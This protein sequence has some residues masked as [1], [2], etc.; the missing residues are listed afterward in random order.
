MNKN[1]LNILKKIIILGSGLVFIFALTFYK[2]DQLKKLLQL[3]KPDHISVLYLRLLLNITPDNDDLR[4]ELANQYINLGQYDNA[5]IELKSLLAKDGRHKAKALDARLLMLE[6]DLNDY[7]LITSDAARRET[8][9]TKLQTSIIKISKNPIPV[10]LFPKVI[11]LSLG[12]D[13]PAIAANLYYQ[14]STFSLDLDSRF[15]KLKESAQWYIASGLPYKATEIY[16]ECY[17]L[18]EN[19]TLARQYALLAL[20]TLQSAG[21]N[22]LALEYFRNYQQRFPEDPELLDEAINISLR[23]NNPEQAYELGSLRLALDPDNPEQ[24]KKQFDRA[25]AIGK[26]Q[27]ALTLTQ[28]LIEIVPDDDNIHERLAQIAEWSEKPKLAIKEWLWLA[29]N[30]KDIPAILN[31]VRLS[32]QLNLFSITIEMLEQLSNMRELS[33]EEMSSLLYAYDNLSNS[34]VSK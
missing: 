31:A 20:Q 12:L 34:S 10:S 32:T 17:E 27:S 3:T 25:L 16:N 2:E 1:L 28:R 6:I 29:R 24:I 22:K 23:S 11:K 26:T 21:D 19:A 13:Q 33:S 5:R 14:W 30:R 4:I 8:E 15:E 7:F 18:A 9:L